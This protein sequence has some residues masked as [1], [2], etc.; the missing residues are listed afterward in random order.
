MTPEEIK[1]LR[2]LE[3]KATKGPWAALYDS[4]VYNGAIVDCPDAQLGNR[5]ALPPNP[6]D[7]DQWKADSKYI[8]ASR[9]ALPKLLDEVERL[10][11]EKADYPIRE[12][13]IPRMIELERNLKMLREVAKYSLEIVKYSKTQEPTRGQN[14]AFQVALMDLGK[15]VNKAKDGGAM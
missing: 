11:K 12:K 10:Q 7:E 5:I 6:D 3:A 1:E 2:E 14:I 9:N 15:A 8:A 4:S 13:C